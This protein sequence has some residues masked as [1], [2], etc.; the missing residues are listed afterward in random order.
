MKILTNNSLIFFIAFTLQLN[1]L[2]AQENTLF[3]GRKHKI[4]FVYGYGGQD[5]SYMLS[6]LNNGKD[7]E[8]ETDQG[9]D[10]NGNS[11][12]LNY[13]YQVTFYQFQYY[14]SWLRRKTWGLDLLVQPQYNTTRYRPVDKATQEENGFEYGLNI[15]VLL[16]KNIFEDF[17]SLYALISLGPHYVS[18]TPQR[19]ASGFIFSDN[20][21]VGM[22]LRLTNNMYLDIRPGFRHISNAGLK[23]PNGGIN[24]FV[25]TAGM[26]VI[27]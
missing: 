4:G 22:N 10:P 24:N 21:F 13:E 1:F 20:L 7:N 14:F 17:M 2:L 18:G 23:S 25:F 3:K 19:Q 16:R 5:P 11:G 27:L 9:T 26:L 12:K 8:S 6:I 15:G